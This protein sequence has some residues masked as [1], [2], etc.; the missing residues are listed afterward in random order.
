[1]LQLARGR[2]QPEVEVVIAKDTVVLLC[3]VKGVGSHAHE[4]MHTW[5]LSHTGPF[6]PERKA[7]AINPQ[8]TTITYHWDKIENLDH[9]RPVSAVTRD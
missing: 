8:P 3:F 1:M 7:L 2:H 4:I 5:S 9:V 6:T